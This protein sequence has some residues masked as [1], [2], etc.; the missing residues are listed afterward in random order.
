MSKE[1]SDYKKLVTTVSTLQD[2]V[3]DLHVKIINLEN[4]L[5]SRFIKEA[6]VEN[7]ITCDKCEYTASSNSVLKRHNSM[8]HKKSLNNTPEKMREASH[9]ESLQLSPISDERSEEITPLLM[10]Q[11]LSDPTQHFKCEYCDTTTKSKHALKGHTDFNHTLNLPHTS[12]WEENKCYIC[13]KHFN[14][15]I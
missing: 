9:D 7:K 15:T 2:Q 5:K 11:V 12:E 3:K 1:E 13:S 14:Y 6:V 10:D 4:E 8:K